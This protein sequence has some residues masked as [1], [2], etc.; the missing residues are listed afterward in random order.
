MRFLTALLLF[1]PALAFSQGIHFE[2]GD[3]KGVLAKAKKENKLVY[4]DVYTTWCGPCKVLAATIFPQKEAGD[5]YNAHFVNYRIDAEKGEGIALAEKYGVNGFPTHLFINPK[6]EAVV[7]RPMGVPQTVAGFNEY[8]KTAL[9]E[10]ADPM[11][12]EIY[13]AEFKKGKKSPQFL[14]AYLQK[15][16]RLDKPNDAILNAYVATLPAK[17]I[18]DSTLYFLADQTK[19]I[20]NNAVPVLE[21]HRSRLAARDSGENFYSYEGLSE[22]WLYASYEAALA[23]KSETKLKTLEAFI[24]KNIPEEDQIGQT[25]FYR[26][27]FYENIGNKAKL[28]SAETEEATLLAAKTLSDFAVGDEKVRK[29]ISKQ[30]RYQLTANPLPEG[31][32]TDSF[33]AAGMARNAGA[34]RSVNAASTLNNLAW[35]TYKNPAATA[36]DLAQALSWSAKALEFS[37]LYPQFWAAHADTHA[38]LL[39]RTGK[40]TEAIVLE[41]KALDILEAAGEKKEAAEYRETLQKMKEGSY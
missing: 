40:K 3:W 12:W 34:L 13:T 39:Y 23:E 15:A 37:G 31:A 8:A 20:W 36:A 9:A 11:T 4:V 1:A 25:F 29:S 21:V 30:L 7:Y 5:V 19:T 27:K 17:D 32:D 33:I 6:T 2:D 28:R 35:K 41:E 26:K 14:K 22:R 10:R 38:S 16:E 24:R 18:P